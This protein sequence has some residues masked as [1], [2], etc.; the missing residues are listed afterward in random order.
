MVDQPGPAAAQG[1]ALEFVHQGLDALAQAGD[2]S[3]CEARAALDFGEDRL[4]RQ[5]Q[6][7]CVTCRFGIHQRRPLEKHHRLAEAVPGA[8]DA[9]EPLAA[10]RLRARRA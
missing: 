6:H 9:G 7:Q 5:L 1:L 8:D 4:L 2:H 3:P 10:R